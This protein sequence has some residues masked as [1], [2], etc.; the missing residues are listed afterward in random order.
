[1][2]YFLYMS[3]CAACPTVISYNPEF[4]PSIRING[5]KEA[6]C[7][8]CF[9]CWNEIHRTAKGLPP[10]QLHPQAYAPV[11]EDDHASE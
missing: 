10:I 5:E 1:M 6:I 7:E 8:A 2:G 11:S 4:V 9:N 3:G